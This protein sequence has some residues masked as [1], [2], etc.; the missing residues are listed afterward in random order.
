MIDYE[1]MEV[2]REYSRYPK[3]LRHYTKHALIENS[4]FDIELIKYKLKGLL[5]GH[6]NGKEDTTRCEAQGGSL[7]QKIRRGLCFGLLFADGNT[8]DSSGENGAIEDRY[9]EDSEGEREE[10]E[11]SDSECE[12]ETQTQTHED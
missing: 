11:E 1:S 3:G 12:K 5:K 8:A 2:E 7:T 6:D 4:L 10:H 9:L